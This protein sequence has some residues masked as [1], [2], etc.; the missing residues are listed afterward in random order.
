MVHLI[1]FPMIVNYRQMRATHGGTTCN[2]SHNDIALHQTHR[3]NEELRVKFPDQPTRFVDSETD[4]DE[5]INDLTRLAAAPQHYGE[6]T[7]LAPR[8]VALLAHENSDIA[9]DTVRLIRELT[10]EDVLP[11]DVADQEAAVAGMRKFV[12]ALVKQHVV[13]ALVENLARLDEE[14]EEEERGVFAVLGIKCFSCILRLLHSQL[15]LS[16]PFNSRNCGEF[17]L[18]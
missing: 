12:E 2:N 15:S 7:P 1:Y 8:L 6:L 16:L 5:A 3:K 13:E 4:L 11:E 17:H 18:G 9:V 10:D 14:K